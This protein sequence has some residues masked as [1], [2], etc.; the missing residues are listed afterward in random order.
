MFFDYIYLQCE[1]NSLLSHIYLQVGTLIIQL[2]IY[3]FGAPNIYLHISEWIHDHIRNWSTMQLL[4]TSFHWIYC[5]F[6]PV[7]CVDINFRCEIA[8]NFLLHIFIR[9]FKIHNVVTVFCEP[10]ISYVTIWVMPFNW[11]K[12]N[13]I[14]EHD[15]LSFFKQC[16][17]WCHSFFSSSIIGFFLCYTK[18]YTFKKL[19]KYPATTRGASTSK[20]SVEPTGS[21]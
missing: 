17:S 18:K 6:T 8:L 10:P 21:W 12:F 5:T 19:S 15:C 14:M 16:L 9:N 2:I 20:W 13:F 11:W 7:V 1:Y 3:L 4:I